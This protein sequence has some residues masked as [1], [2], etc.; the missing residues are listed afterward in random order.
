MFPIF[1]FRTALLGPVTG[2]FSGNP[3]LGLVT[4]TAYLTVHLRRRR[5]TAVSGHSFRVFGRGYPRMGI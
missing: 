5:G 4:I 3:S 2:P 1:S